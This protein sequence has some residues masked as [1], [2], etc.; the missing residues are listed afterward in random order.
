MQSQVRPEWALPK[1]YLVEEHGELENPACKPVDDFYAAL[2]EGMTLR[3]RLRANPTRRIETKSGTD[4]QRRN[5]K[6]VELR[7]EE[8]WLALLCP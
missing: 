7:G 2:T 8:Q 3:F 1:G 4:G 6:R 5:G